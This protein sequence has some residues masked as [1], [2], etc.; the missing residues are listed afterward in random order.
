MIIIAESPPASGR[1]FYDVEGAVTEPLFSALMKQLRLSPTIKER[2]L[3]AFQQLGWL[4]VDATYEPVNILSEANR[5]K[6]ILRDYSLLRQDL[7]DIVGKNSTP[8]V[9]IKANICRLLGPRLVADGL[10]VINQGRH[11]YFPSHGRQPQ[12]HM[13]FQEVLKTAG[14]Q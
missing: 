1:Y 7:S 8:L 2:G 6:I 5:Q 13:Q 10:T 4:L 12:F 9:L 3:R 14:M 11:I